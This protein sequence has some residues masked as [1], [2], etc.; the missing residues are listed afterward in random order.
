MTPEFTIQYFGN[1]YVSTGIYSRFKRFTNPR[2]DDFAQRFEVFEGDRIFYD[3]FD[4]R[5]YF[6]ETGDGTFDYS[7]ANPDFNFREFRS[8][9]VARWEYTPGSV[10]YVVWTQGR[11]LFEGV[12]NESLGHNLGNLFSTPAENVFLVKLSYWLPL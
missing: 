7:I 12:T 9:L 8:N 1:P 2:A 4:R 11:S 3:Q 6:D 5:Y 10:L